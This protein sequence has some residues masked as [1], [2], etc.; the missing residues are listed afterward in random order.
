M[1]TRKALVERIALARHQPMTE[2][3]K[4]AQRQSFAFGNAGLE[5]DRVTRRVVDEAVRRVSPKKLA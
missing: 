5:N 1:A 2:Q 4:Q 3:Q